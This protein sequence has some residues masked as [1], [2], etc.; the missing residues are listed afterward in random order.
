[1]L[2]EVDARAAAEVRLLLGER[3]RILG[4]KSRDSDELE[5]PPTKG[6]HDR[7][8]GLHRREVRLVQQDDRT[9]NEPS[10]GKHCSNYLRGGG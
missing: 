8:H 4:K 5:A 9:G 3:G 1:M 6:R 7:G 10:I 2:E